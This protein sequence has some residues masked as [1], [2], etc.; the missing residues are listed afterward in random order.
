MK[1]LFWIKDVEKSNKEPVDLHDI[2]QELRA[3][4]H[5]LDKL[6]GCIDSS[7]QYGGALKTTTSTRY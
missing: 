7:P 2:R 3:L 1:L 5:K 6:V 4:N